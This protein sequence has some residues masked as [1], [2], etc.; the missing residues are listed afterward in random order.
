MKK[1]LLKVALSAILLALLFS[2]TNI[3]ELAAAVEGVSAGVIAVVILLNLLMVAVNSYRW[4]VLLMAQGVDVPLSR[5]FAC[6]LTGIFFNNFLPGSVGGD[7]YRVVGVAGYFKDKEDA[8]PSVFMERVLGLVVLV[9]VSLAAFAVSFPLVRDVRLVVISEAALVATLLAILLFFR[10][11]VLKA[12]NFM[13]N[14]FFRLFEKFDLKERAKKVY[15]G[16]SGYKDDK[17]RF[18]LAVLLS[19]VSRVVWIY[20]CY[21]LS[22]GMGHSLPMAVYF[23]LLPLIEFVRMFPVSINGLGVR[24]GA[25]VLYFGAFGLGISDALVFSLLVY[26]VLLVIG[27]AGGILYGAR[28]W[29]ARKA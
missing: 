15:M 26:A 24:E 11:S 28:G 25:F 22:A 2:R 27:V 5:L 16:L 19:V 6:Y 29:V 14:P 9:P 21:L 23:L 7:V 4:K 1:D 3:D 20:G 13:Y 10:L 17:A 12:F 8:L 18:G